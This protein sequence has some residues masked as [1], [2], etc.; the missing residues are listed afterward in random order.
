[1]IEKNT[2]YVIIWRGQYYP[3]RVVNTYG[4]GG[5][6]S[7]VVNEMPGSDGGSVYTTGRNTRRVSLNGTMVVSRDD[8]YSLE[9]VRKD[10][11]TIRDSGEVITLITPLMSNEAGRYIIEEFSGTLDA[12][13]TRS[14]S[15]T[16]TLVEFKPS[17]VRN[18]GINLV[19]LEPFQGVSNAIDFLTTRGALN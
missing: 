1:M 2:K 3:I 18:A 5:T 4:F 19:A 8:N 12:G 6:Q 14:F 15:F 17:N 7:V 9:Q 13:S 10:F 16:L 11:E